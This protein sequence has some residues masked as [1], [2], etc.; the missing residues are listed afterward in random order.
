MK[1]ILLSFA[2]L[3]SLSHISLAAT[4]NT[5]FTSSAKL[6]AS[7]TITAND[8]DLG[9]LTANGAATTVSKQ[10]GFN[11]LC[12]R[13]ASFN[14]LLDI[15]VNHDVNG[16]RFLKGQN[17]ADTIQYGICQSSS[18]STSPFSCSTAWWGTGYIFARTG[19]YKPDMYSDT[20]VTT[21][22]F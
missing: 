16:N 22:N 18:F 13:N 3:L 20:V 1:K 19:Y 12:S 9:D 10:L 21:I 17:S 14:V 4:T 6:S 11:V 5:N 7:C 15:G 8:L 2:V